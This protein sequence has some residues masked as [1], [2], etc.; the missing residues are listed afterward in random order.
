MLATASGRIIHFAI[1]EVNVLQGVG[2]GVIGIKLDDNDSCLGVALIGS[3]FDALTVETTNGQT[4]EYKRG[5]HPPT[6]RGGRGYEVVKRGGLARVVPPP[7]ELVDWD[8][9]EA[10]SNREAGR[11]GKS[12]RGLFDGSN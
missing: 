11:N 9:V 1:D 12:G 8:S 7:I 10:E 4:K 6:G 2:K 3:R 5:A